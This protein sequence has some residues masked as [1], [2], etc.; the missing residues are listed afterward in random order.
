MTNS[1][2]KLTSTW[3]LV[4]DT[5]F[6][7]AGVVLLGSVLDKLYDKAN[8]LLLPRFKVRV[9]LVD[10]LPAKA[11]ES[12]ACRGK[13]LGETAIIFYVTVPLQILSVSL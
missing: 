7:I 8:K 9:V 10:W 13:I 5:T 4:F 12:E 3:V 6:Y 2:L 1:F 11:N